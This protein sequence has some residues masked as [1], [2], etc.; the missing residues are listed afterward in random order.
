MPYE[1]Y[2]QHAI[3]F[4]EIKG[5][6]HSSGFRKIIGN[7]LGQSPINVCALIK[8]KCHQLNPAITLGI[9]TSGITWF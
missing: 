6:F 3:K 1:Q 4:N 7:R 8:L 9:S 2:N 5:D